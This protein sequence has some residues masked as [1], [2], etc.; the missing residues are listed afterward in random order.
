MIYESRYN[1]AVDIPELILD[2]NLK[3]STPDVPGL[4][5]G[6]AGKVVY[7]F[8]NLRL[9]IS[10]FWGILTTSAGNR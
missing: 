7:T 1:E 8:E 3:G 5:D 10:N 6:E 9:H 2:R 4:I